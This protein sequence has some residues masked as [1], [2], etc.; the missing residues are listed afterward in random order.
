MIWHLIE[1][2]RRKDRW[3]VSSDHSYI[4][5]YILHYEEICKSNI[6]NGTQKIIQIMFRRTNRLPLA[7]Y[8]TGNVFPIWI[9]L[10]TY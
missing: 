10:M 6:A 5:I 1:L 9:K 7:L 8:H 4:Y 2:D 3:K